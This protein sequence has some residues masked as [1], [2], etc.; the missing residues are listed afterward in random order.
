MAETI[1]VVGVA[2]TSA[3]GALRR[4]LATFECADVC[5]LFVGLRR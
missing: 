5:N 2:L 4:K 3:V 1:R